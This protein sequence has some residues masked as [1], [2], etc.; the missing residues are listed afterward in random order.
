ME[1]WKQ[2]EGYENYYIS[3]HGR[4]YSTNYGGRILKP[5]LDGKHNYLQVGLSKNNKVHKESIH[6]LVALAFIP[7][8]DNKPEVNHKDYDSTNNHVNNLEWV[9]REENMRHCFEL[10]SQVRYFKECELY[11]GDILIGKFQTISEACRYASDEYGV[12]YSMLNRYKKVKDFKILPKTQT[13]I[14]QESTPE[15]KL[16]VEV[17]TT[18]AS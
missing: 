12:S 8:V 18:L 16:L 10:H 13:T 15:D 7:N 11:K 4:V 9:T 1:E 14:S 17:P 5:W 3:S 2:I 6:R